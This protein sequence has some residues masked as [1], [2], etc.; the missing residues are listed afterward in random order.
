MQTLLFVVK[1]LVR[2]KWGLISKWHEPYRAAHD[3][4]SEAE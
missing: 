4:L 1:C 2:R 3:Y